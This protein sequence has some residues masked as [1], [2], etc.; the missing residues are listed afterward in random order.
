MK[1]LNAV[2]CLS[3]YFLCKIDAS[4]LLSPV[5]PV[6]FCNANACV[7]WFCGAARFYFAWFQI[8]RNMRVKIISFHAHV[9]GFN[10]VELSI[11][12]YCAVVFLMFIVC[13]VNWSKSMLF[14]M[15]VHVRACICMYKWINWIISPAIDF[16][17]RWA[18]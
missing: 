13:F 11:G 8:T 5:R 6:Q 2:L 1:N 7:R 17:Q 3:F 18:K 15:L 12:F 4:A 16:S 14:Q 10:A 9:H